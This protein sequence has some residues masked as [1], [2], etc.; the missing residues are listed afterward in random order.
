MRIRLRQ[1]E[2][3]LEQAGAAAGTTSQRAP[4]RCCSPSR[5]NVTA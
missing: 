5:S 1:A 2:L 4:M 3:A